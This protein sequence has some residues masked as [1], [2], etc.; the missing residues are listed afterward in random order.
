M[1]TKT[2]MTVAALAIIVETLAAKI[3]VLESRPTRDRGPASENAMTEDHARTVLLGDDMGLSHKAAAEKHGLS[4]GQVYSARNGFTF[5]AV[6]KE[7]RDAE[8]AAVA[9]DEA[10]AAKAAA[11]AAKK[12]ET[13]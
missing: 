7:L 13:A 1:P 5:K 4:Y 9:A 2:K 6:Y 8:A 10:K 12:P 3:E 11:K